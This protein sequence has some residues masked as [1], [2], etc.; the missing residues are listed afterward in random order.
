MSRISGDWRRAL[1]VLA[2]GGVIAY[3]TEA[4][5]GLG[6][7][8]DD[9]QAVAR[10]RALKSRP[11]ATGMIVLIDNLDQLRDWIR[12][13]DQAARRRLQASWP[14]PE[15]WLMPASAT[16]PAWL[17]GGDRLAVRLP[18]HDLCR[19]LTRELDVPLV[20]TSANRRDRPPA[21][22]ADEVARIFANE[23]DLILDGPLGT[24]ARPSR[25]RDL[26]TGEV[27]RS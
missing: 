25:I 20:S 7:R 27:I 22:N 2:G 26:E 15:T 13:P 21:R 11:P 19:R 17:G 23:L 24:R 8:A 9:E 10:I 18:D 5:Y 12:Q 6:C 4:V 16:C 3:P 14:G 1:A